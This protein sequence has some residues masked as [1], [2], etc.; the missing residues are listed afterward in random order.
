MSVCCFALY[1][2]WTLTILVTFPTW[3]PEKNIKTHILRK[4]LKPF[5]CHTQEREE[6]QR[7]LNL[8][9]EALRLLGNA[10]VALSDL[11][12]NLLSPAPR[13]LH[14]IRP[15]SHYTSPVSMPGAVHHHIPLHV[16]WRCIPLSNLFCCDLADTY[17][18]Y[19]ISVLCT[20]PVKCFRT[21]THSS[22]FLYFPP[23]QNTASCF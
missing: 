22:N 9:G 19:I 18:Y 15:M 4:W 23:T 12:C 1:C 3:L 16:S 8:V 6:D 17:T 2:S 13:H 10:L 21:P 11:R 5:S 20:L 7:I 14:V